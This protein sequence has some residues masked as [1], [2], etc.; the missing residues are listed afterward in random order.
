MSMTPED[1]QKALD[2]LGISQVAAA[3]M[4]KVGDRTVAA[5]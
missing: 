5:L 2:K 3:R 1:Y 4:F